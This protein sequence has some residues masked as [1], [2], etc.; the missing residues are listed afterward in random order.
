M[1]SPQLAD[2]PQK[3]R[4]V[5]FNQRRIQL[6]M[7]VLFSYIIGS[8]LMFATGIVAMQ[9][10]NDNTSFIYGWIHGFFV[11]P[12]FVAS[13]ASDKYSIYQNGGGPFYNLFYLAGIFYML[14]NFRI[15]FRK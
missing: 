12:E 5:D 4:S 7:A 15:L 3:T 10:H 1:Q 8:S 13:L 14:R 2:R 6:T 9:A 11:L